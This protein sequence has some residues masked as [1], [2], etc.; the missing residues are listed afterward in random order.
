MVPILTKKFDSYYNH[1]D[2]SDNYF[3]NKENTLSNV[4]KNKQDLK[5][6][7]K[8]K[9]H[10]V[11]IDV[12]KISIFARILQKQ[13]K[14]EEEEKEQYTEEQIISDKK[15]SEI[16][17]NNKK[18][19]FNEILFIEE[20]TISKN[21]LIN[22]KEQIL[23]FL[24]K[25][26]YQEN[27]KVQFDEMSSKKVK[28]DELLLNIVKT[29]KK[30]ILFE[31]FKYDTPKLNSKNKNQPI[32]NDFQRLVKNLIKILEH[33]GK[34]LKHK[35]ETMNS[36]GN[37][38]QNIVIEI[39]DKLNSKFTGV[40]ES[41][42]NFTSNLGHIFFMTTTSKNKKIKKKKRNSFLNMSGQSS[43][44]F[45]IFFFFLIKNKIFMK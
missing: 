36:N 17:K 27:K 34:S 29:V 2:T 3:F 19:E 28:F 35:Y 6:N 7:Q 15:T 10:D 39:F 45:L 21:Q 18:L 31:V 1:Q 20:E 38:K 14:K 12:A 37:T 32:Q 33:D 23:E 41:V 9:M 30:L 8:R 4:I 40:T 22:L 26:I 44:H 5:I 43:K 42:K 13:I 24:E 11:I 16:N 25:E